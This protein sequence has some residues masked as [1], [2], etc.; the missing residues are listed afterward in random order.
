MKQMTTACRALL[1]AAGAT[2]IATLAGA[3]AAQTPPTEPLQGSWRFSAS[4]G[5]FVPRSALILA[6]DGHNTEL[7][8]GPHFSLDVQYLATKHAAVYADAST[9]FS[10]IFLGSSIRPTVVGP[11]NQVML[12]GGTT[13]VLVSLPT[14]DHLQVTLRL[15]GGFKW[16]SFDLTDAQDQW[17]PTGDI[18]LGLRG[19]GAGPI[20]VTMEVRYL[21]SSFDQG[22]LPIRGIAPQAQRQNDLLV[23]IGVSIRP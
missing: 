23:A 10:T 7:A 18:G 4:A 9:N 22:K 8:A 12:V 5:A 17:R 13:G 15:G 6:A 2:L 1:L 3:Q 19:V 21:P 20:E 14:S 16:Y 11:S